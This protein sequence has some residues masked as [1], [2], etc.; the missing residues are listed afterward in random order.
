MQL[1][2]RFYLTHGAVEM[3]YPSMMTPEDVQDFKD[4]MALIFRRFDRRI[5]REKSMPDANG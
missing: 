1:L 4:N 5:E 3:S 2:D